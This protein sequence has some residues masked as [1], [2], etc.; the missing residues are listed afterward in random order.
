MKSFLAL[1][2]LILPLYAGQANEGGLDQGKAVFRSNCAFCHGLT[3]QGGRGPNLIS[4]ALLHSG[5]DDAIKVIINRGVPGTTMPAFDL[6]KDDL[7]NL[8]QFL[9]SLS[10]SHA[11]GPKSA[12]RSCRR[13]VGL[14]AQRLR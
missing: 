2:T 1:I 12:G 3:A 8:L 6:Q 7:D 5:A 9:H 4:S 13:R 11:A 14:L 10:G